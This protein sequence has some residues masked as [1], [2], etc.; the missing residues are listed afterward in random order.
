MKLYY[1]PLSRYS[2]KVL[3]AFYEKQVKFEPILVSLMSPEGRAEFEQVYPLGK[4]P[5]LKPA[6]DY[7]IP[8]SSIIIEYLE[9][10]YSSGTRLIPEGVDAARK[11]RFMDRMSDLYFADPSQVLLFE[12]L[13]FQKHSEA[14]LSKASKHLQ[15]SYEHFD[16]RLAS[17]DWLC[18]DFS[19]ADCALIPSLFYNQ[20]S[21]PYRDYPH[22]V[23]YFE[24]AKQRPSYAKV[25]A[26]FVPIWEGLQNQGKP[27]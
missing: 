25:M 26:E 21:A 16:K 14:E 3:I 11:V 5:L 22:L 17:Q 6:D 12:K 10:H 13:G 19:M 18:G 7:M 2:Q 24:R 4:I 27:A 9:G 20:F 23:A 15:I 1:N 8:E